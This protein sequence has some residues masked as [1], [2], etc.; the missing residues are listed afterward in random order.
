MLRLGTTGRDPGA[1]TTPTTAN[2]NKNMEVLKHTRNKHPSLHLMH[3]CTYHT[4]VVTT[5]LLLP[6][7]KNGSIH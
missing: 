2:N 5:V 3:S 1:A 4:A 6:S 7:S